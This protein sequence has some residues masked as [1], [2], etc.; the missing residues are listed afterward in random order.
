[1]NPVAKTQD[2]LDFNV[3]EAQVGLSKRGTIQYVVSIYLHIYE[4]LI[5]SPAKMLLLG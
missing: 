1:M 3:S 2:S 5:F 4:R